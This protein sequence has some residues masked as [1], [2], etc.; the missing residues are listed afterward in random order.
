MRKLWMTDDSSQSESLLNII[1]S[2]MLQDF[3][4]GNIFTSQELDV[5]K[6]AEVAHLVALTVAVRAPAAASVPPNYEKSIPPI[7]MSLFTQ[8]EWND[9]VGAELKEIAAKAAPTADSQK[10]F[11]GGLREWAN[12][13][14]MF[15][16][17]VASNDT[18][19][20]DGCILTI[21]DQGLKAICKK[22]RNIL[23]V[24][25]YENV[26]NFRYDDNEFVVRTGDS[27]Y[28]GMIRFQTRQ[29]F[30]IADL[31]HSYI[32]VRIHVSWR[33]SSKDA[34]NQGRKASLL[35]SE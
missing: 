2:Q 33:P 18:R 15:F 19:F 12:F 28:P 24:C 11:L 21:N 13:G 30:V 14:G 23:M 31:I 4:S 34:L 1:Y 26:V 10:N 22:T 29:G 20:L 9:V 5:S 17:I 25:G 8:K 16:N 6:R 32:H 27:N 35:A 7:A 3:V